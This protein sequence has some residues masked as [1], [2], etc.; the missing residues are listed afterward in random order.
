MSVSSDNEFTTLPA[1]MSLTN[2]LSMTL[3][4]PGAIFGSIKIGNRNAT[5][6]L[7]ALSGI[8]RSERTFD[9]EVTSP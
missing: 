5:A 4:K 1:T 2:P 9:I 7:R 6:D 3:T 8:G